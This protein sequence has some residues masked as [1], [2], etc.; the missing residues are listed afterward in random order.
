MNSCTSSYE[1]FCVCAR[2]EHKLA[3]FV[4]LVCVD[5]SRYL[6]VGEEARPLASELPLD[7]SSISSSKTKT[8]NELYLFGSN[9]DIANAL[10]PSQQS[11]STLGP[12]LCHARSDHSTRTTAAKVPARCRGA[13]AA[14]G[15]VHLAR[16][17]GI[18]G[19]EL[20]PGF[21]FGRGSKHFGCFGCYGRSVAWDGAGSRCNVS[22]KILCNDGIPNLASS[23]RFVAYEKSERPRGK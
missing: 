20:G 22:R 6:T 17:R 5:W 1:H 16:R 11:S 9:L 14:A 10:G 3:Q 19:L 21:S 15:H 23:L 8:T 4:V 7:H 18:L 13:L 12:C 2:D